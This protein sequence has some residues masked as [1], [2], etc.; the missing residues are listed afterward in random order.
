M[1]QPNFATE[2]NDCYTSNENERLHE[3]LLQSNKMSEKTWDCG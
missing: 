1:A 2:Y 3:K